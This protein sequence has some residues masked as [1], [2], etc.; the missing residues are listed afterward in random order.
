MSRN[1][2]DNGLK[3]TAAWETFASKAYRATKDEKYLTIGFGHYGSDVKPTDTMTE[4]EAYLLLKKDMAE[5][6]KLADSIASLKFNQA[7]FDAICDLIFNVGPKAVAAGTGTG[8]AVR[9]GDVK[10]LESKLPQFRNQ[11]GK[12]VL[13]I[14]RRAMGRLALFQ[15]K[16]WEEAEK[17]GRGIKS[18]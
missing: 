2:S 18:L 11:A 6:V 5:A 8:Q 17:Y 16:S 15:G 9:A 3:F 14:Y 7:Q 1:I 10:T 13:G 4:A 12:P